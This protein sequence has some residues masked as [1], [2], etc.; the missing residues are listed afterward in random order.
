MSHLA[1]G[2]SEL[3]FTASNRRTYDR[4]ARRYADRQ[5]QLPSEAEHWL[6]DLED[7]FVASLPPGGIVGDLG[8]G[9]AYDGLR[10][11][12]KGLQVVGID[13]SAGMLE[14]AAQHLGAHL[15]QADLRAL[16]IASQHLDGIWNVASMLHI[17]EHDTVAVLTEFRRIMKP[18]GSFVLVT[19]L[20]D[21]SRHEAVPYASD[22]SRWFVYRDPMVLRAQM[23]DAGFV[24]QHEKEVQ[25]NRRWWT[26]LGSTI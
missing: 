24:I 16:P 4:I 9:P 1:G 21:A 26:A 15:I 8:C 3:D 14:V 20:G 25:G 10:L 19:A 6:A 12:D 17:P 7:S 11:A 13:L 5:V 2:A 18:S 22:E 23:T